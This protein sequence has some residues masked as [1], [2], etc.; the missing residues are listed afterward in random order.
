[1]SP[2]PRYHWNMQ[3]GEKYRL[4]RMILMDHLGCAVRRILDTGY[5]FQGELVC[6]EEDRIDFPLVFEGGKVLRFSGRENG[7][8]IRL[9]QDRWEDPFRE[10]LD[11]V[12]RT[13][14]EAH[15][16]AVEWEATDDPE[17]AGHIGKGLAAIGEVVY[18]PH[19]LIAGNSLHFT[20]AP[21]LYIYNIW[22]QVK[23][24]RSLDPTE[25]REHL[26]NSPPGNDGDT[27]TV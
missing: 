2:F 15:G 24:E 23:V 10:P 14:I 27:A 13:Y 3:W 22:D 6:G 8:G 20:H 5:L 9:Y 19:N 18:L 4:N 12:N 1:M 26:L 25:L 21:A 17:W 7:F 11:E 16:K